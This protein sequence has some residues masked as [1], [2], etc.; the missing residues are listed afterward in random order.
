MYDVVIFHSITFGSSNN[1]NN[2][3]STNSSIVFII[4]LKSMSCVFRVLVQIET[5]IESVYRS[6]E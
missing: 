3:E 5:E 1:N 2:N 4:I 6:V